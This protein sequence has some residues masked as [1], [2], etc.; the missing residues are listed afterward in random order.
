LSSEYKEALDLQKQT[1][2]KQRREDFLEAQEVICSFF[3]NNIKKQSPD[4]LLQQFD[5][6]FI[7]QSEIVHSKVNQA[8]YAIIV[9]NQ[10]KIFRNTLKRCCYILINNWSAA[11][12]TQHIQKLVQ[13]F[14]QVSDN[15]N[16]LALTKKRLKE[17]LKNFYNSEDYQELRLFIS[18][19]SNR[20]KDRWSN[21]YA[22]YLLTS[23]AVDSKNPR[24][25][26]EAA[27]VVATQLKDQ[28]KLDLAMYTAH[29]QLMVDSV[30]K[31]KNPT[32]LGNDVLFLIHKILGKRGIYSY[33]S[34]ANIF[35]KQVDGLLYKK[36]KQGFLKYL[37]FSL[38]NPQLVE[39]LEVYLSTYI[40]LLYE[41]H[42]EEVWNSYLLLRSCN[43][44]IEYL[45]TQKHGRPSRV[46]SL[47]VLQGEYLVLA[48]LLL[49]IILVSKSSYIHLEACIGYLIQFYE[50]ESESECQWLIKFLE[51]L[52]LVLTIYAENIRYN[53]VPTEANLLKVEMN[54]DFSSYRIF[55]QVKP[56]QERAY[57]NI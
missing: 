15:Q 7:S 38:E 54:D 18:K 19:Y 43:R 33:A 53:L 24:E 6:L 27:R 8:L 40:E 45:T 35:L 23:Q 49:K 34:L 25:Q 1:G 12:Y 4:W 56:K 2:Y 29:S 36:V 22:S 47:L 48:I 21:R 16:Y 37:L 20:E 52:K 44:L 30:K 41:K 3:L 26:R 51:I 42:N 11:R 14:S 9:L 10:E 55:S 31:Y 5:N 32:F 50:N 57:Q 13:L 46:F 17:W 39:I 28:F